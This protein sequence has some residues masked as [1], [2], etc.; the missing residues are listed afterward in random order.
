M[1]RG[2]IA[3]EK[4]TKPLEFELVGLAFDAL[5]LGVHLACG[6]RVDPVAQLFHHA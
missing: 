4:I 2:V 5:K 6:A 3:F 1:F